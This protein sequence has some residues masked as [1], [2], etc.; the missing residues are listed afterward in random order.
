MNLIIEFISIE[1][2]QKVRILYGNHLAITGVKKIKFTA[3]T[4]QWETANRHDGYD[5]SLIKEIIIE[6]S[7]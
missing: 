3:D 7:E 4:I 2:A 1:A 5:M 6:E